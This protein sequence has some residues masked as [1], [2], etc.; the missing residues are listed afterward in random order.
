[1]NIDYSGSKWLPNN[2]YADTSFQGNVESNPSNSKQQSSYG[3][4]IT[5]PLQ[6]FE[7]TGSE[8]PVVENSSISKEEMAE[9]QKYSFLFFL[10]LFIV[11]V[12]YS[13]VKNWSFKKGIKE[14]VSP[15]EILPNIKNFL[16]IG[17]SAVLFRTLFKMILS[18]LVMFNIPFI[19]KC[20]SG[21]L[22]LVSM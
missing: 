10:G 15:K 1:M 7:G 18:K 4:S 3:Q 6:Y 14:S 13:I 11:Y 9:P 21:L 17:L 5:N 2:H 16:I 19:S 22:P 8:N 20:A 12:I